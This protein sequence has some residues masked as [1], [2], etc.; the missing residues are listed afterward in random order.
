[1]NIVQFYPWI[2]LG[3]I[4][5]FIIFNFFYLLLQPTYNLPIEFKIKKGSSV[6]QIAEILE[7]N[8]IISSKNVFKFYLLISGKSNKIKAGHYKI[9][10]PVNIVQLANILV[11]G[12]VGLK[13]KILPGMT[14]KDI[15]KL[16]ND[17]NLKVKLTNYHLKDFPELNLHRLFG[18]DKSLEGFLFPDTYEFLENESEREIIL[19]ILKN[20][21][22]KALPLIEKND[23]PYQVLI[24]AS[25]LEKE[26]IPLEDKFLASDILWKRIK[27][28]IKLEVDAT[29]VYAKC[30]GY[31][32]FCSDRELTARDIV[33]DNPY[34]TY[35]YKGFPPSPIANPSQ[36]S[37]I[38]AVNPQS[39]DFYFYLTTKDGR[40]IF[41]R[42]FQEH[43]K[44]IKIYLRK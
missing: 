5:L 25:L 28:N 22:K 42:N 26:I 8:G 13:V 15:E 9:E 34:N 11:Q 12:G 19:K 27:E 31:F 38:A 2:I 33:L 23:N 14:L 18:E 41:S 7:K 43:Q 24:I 21:Q 6:D 36:E 29:V 17:L 10:Q 35:K 3:I 39:N 32:Y 30:G 16:L 44:K 4:G 20:F 40:T 1:M 37:L